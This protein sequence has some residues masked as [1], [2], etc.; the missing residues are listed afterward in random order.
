MASDKWYLLGCVLGLV[1][2]SIVISDIDSGTECT[3]SRFAEDTELRG[4]VDT[5]EEGTIQRELDDLN[6]WWSHENLVKFKKS[7]CN[8]AAPGLGQSQTWTQTGR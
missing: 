2:C 6:K 4:G 8:G 3:L 5:T 7:K 1:I